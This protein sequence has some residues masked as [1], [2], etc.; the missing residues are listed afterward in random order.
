MWLRF[1]LVYPGSF[2]NPARFDTF[3][4]EFKLLPTSTPPPTQPECAAIAGGDISAR[5]SSSPSICAW[6]RFSSSLVAFQTS[7]S[8]GG[9]GCGGGA[10]RHT[11]C[12]S[13]D[14]YSHDIQRACSLAMVDALGCQTRQWRRVPEPERFP[15]VRQVSDIDPRVLVAGEDLPGTGWKTH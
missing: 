4:C 11:A 9:G 7:F 2:L 12:S 5:L 10:D 3:T 15:A 8:K 1:D 6:P 13:L 14:K